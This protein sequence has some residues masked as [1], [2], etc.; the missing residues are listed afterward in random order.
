MS[1]FKKLEQLE[2]LEDVS[3]DL[4]AKDE[5]GNKIKEFFCDEWQRGKKGLTL[6]SLITKNPIVKLVILIII[7]AGDSVSDKIC[8]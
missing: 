6:L 7:S 3:I 8:E 5:D 2:K 1:L 4:E